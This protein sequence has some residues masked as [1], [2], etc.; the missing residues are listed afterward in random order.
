VLLI[1]SPVVVLLERI[2]SDSLRKRVLMIAFVKRIRLP[3]SVY[4]LALPATRCLACKNVLTASSRYRRSSSVTNP[5]R[6]A[7]SPACS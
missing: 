3:V 5:G 6:S 2:V 4:T 7:A 1:Y